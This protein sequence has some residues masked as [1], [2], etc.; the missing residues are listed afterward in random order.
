VYR[1]HDH[2]PKV[3][4]Y[5]ILRKLLVEISPYFQLRCS[6]GQSFVG[7]FEV[8]RSKIKVTMRPDVVKN[9][10]GNVEV[11]CWNIKFT[12][13]L[14]DEGILVDASLSKTI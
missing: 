9:H 13:N 10:F 8:K 5:D 7:D 6:W 12:D 1:V 2:I 14:S 4:E 3:C 11:M